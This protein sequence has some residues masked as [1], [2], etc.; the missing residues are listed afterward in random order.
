MRDVRRASNQSDAWQRT[1][2]NQIRSLLLD[3]YVSLPLSNLTHR[4]TTQQTLPSCMR[5]I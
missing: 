3:F 4:S 5:R 2:K 1:V